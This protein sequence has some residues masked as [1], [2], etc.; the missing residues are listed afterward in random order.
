MTNGALVDG[1]MFK[2]NAW[3]STGSGFNAWNPQGGSTA[4]ITPVQGD[5]IHPS[6]FHR[7]QA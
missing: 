7:L 5:L 2:N 4:S 1:S 3:S 6:G